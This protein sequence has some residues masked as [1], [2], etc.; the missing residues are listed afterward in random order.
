VLEDEIL[1][2]VQDDKGGT[3]G[4]VIAPVAQEHHP[5]TNG[6]SNG[7]SNGRRREREVEVDKNIEFSDLGVA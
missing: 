5:R 2:C 3:L 4:S 1:H 6:A 7:A